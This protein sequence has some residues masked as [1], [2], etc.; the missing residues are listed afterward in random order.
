MRAAKTAENSRGTGKPRA[1]FFTTIWNGLSQYGQ[2]KIPDREIRH[3]TNPNTKK[4]HVIDQEE[5]LSLAVCLVIMTYPRVLGLCQK[6][7]VTKKN[8][9]A[10]VCL[11]K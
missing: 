1:C 10:I 8:I 5:S 3:V 4:F 9:K 11:R 7:F 6:P 2:R